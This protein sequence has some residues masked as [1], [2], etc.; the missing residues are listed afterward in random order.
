MRKRWLVVLALLI[1]FNHELL[2]ANKIKFVRI[3]LTG[4]SEKTIQSLGQMK[5]D[6]TYQNRQQGFIEAIA[7]ERQ[8][9]EIRQ[10][11]LSSQSIID[12]LEAFEQQL[13]TS[14]Y[15]DPFHSY[16]E[17]VQEMQQLQNDHPD[18]AMMQSLGKSWEGRDIWAIKISDN[19]TTEEAD[20]AEALFMANIHAREM[21]TPEIIM[22]FMHWL[23]DNYNVDPR[24]TYLVN[25]RQLWLIPTINPDGR[26]YVFTGSYSN[27]GWL[28]G[29]IAWRKNKRDN[30]NNNQFD[31]FYDGVDLNRNFGYM[32]GL[33]A[34]SSGSPSDDT[35]RGPYAFSEP[36]SQAIKNFVAAHRF[37]ISLSY[38][39]YGRWWIFPW[40]Y[41]NIEP[42]TPDH[43]QFVALA[44]SCVAYNGYTPANGDDF[45]YLVSGDTD[46][47][48]YGDQS[49]RNKIFAFTP[50]VGSS[51]EGSFWPDTSLIPKL[52]DENMGPNIFMAF[53]AGEE[54]LIDHIP[55]KETEDPGPYP[56]FA[57]IKP[58]ILLT[59]PVP[60]DPSTFTV[61]FNTTGIAP[62]DSVQLQPTGNPDEYFGEIPAFPGAEKIYYYLSAADRNGRTGWMPRGA[63]MA[64]YAICIGAD[65]VPPVISHTPITAQSIF[66]RAIL[67]SA[68]VTDN[69][70]ISQVKLLYRKNGEE[71]DSLE[72]VAATSANEFQA[73]IIPENLKVGDY[74]EYKIVAIDNSRQKNQAQWPPT[75]FYRFDIKNSLLYDFELEASFAPTFE[76]DWEWGIPTTGPKSAHS[77]SRLWATNLEGNYTDVTESILETPPISLANRDSAKLT[78]WHWYQ[79]EYSDNAFWDGGNVK[80]S[81]DGG[82]FQLLYPEGGYDGIVDP[83]NGYLGNEPC[84]GGPATNGNFWHQEFFDLSPY[85]NHTITIRFHFGSDGAVTDYGWYIDDVEILFSGSTPVAE[86]QPPA[87][88]PLT[89]ELKQNYPNPFNPGTEISYSLE[90]SCRVQLEIFNLAGQ[91]I[92][93]LVDA[94]QPRGQHSVTWHGDDDQRNPVASGI[95]FYQLTLRGENVHQVL[96]KKMLKLM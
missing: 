22:Y 39:S 72:M 14:D 62:F 5:L 69:I 41:T 2:A 6:I 3:D 55:L 12:D 95:Y 88:K 24:A 16:E 91:R 11:G 68:R 50:E 58:P 17:M 94:T 89:F 47:W 28:S 27:T 83:Y 59:T 40:G 73:T 42:D 4:K 79:N 30:N 54:P 64:T 63:P 9:D 13:R 32:W 87:S 23:I 56:I 25:H 37:V 80:I 65:L 92:K 67:I 38:H 46:D 29:P 51:A 93:R 53:A 78:F 85:S 19:V 31:P 96:V 61:F 8:L 18:L 90:K 84:F 45:S 70:G 52:I 35:Y 49:N 75:G 43:L 57:W 26:V 10:L 82:A 76:G 81:V 21:I 7:D 77:G 60:L 33:G 15:F 66:A 34:G 86:Q 48:L 71:V 36:E 1:V 20:E 74:Y 44:E